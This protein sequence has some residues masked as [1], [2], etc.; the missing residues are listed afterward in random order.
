M[1]GTIPPTFPLRGVLAPVLTPFT[2]DLAPDPD[3]FNR[4]CAWLLAHGCVGLAPFGTTSEANSLG[5]EER[6]ALLEGLVASGVDP[7]R[8]IPGTGCCSLPE[9][10]ALS[11]HAAAL[12]CAGAL[13]LPPFYYKGVSD[14]GLFRAYSEV[15]QR[16]GD[17]RLKIFLY[18]IP[19]V[20][21]V[22]VSPALVERLLKAYP[23]TVVGVK[24]SSGDWAN[25]QALLAYARDG[26][27]VFPGSELFLLRGL[28]GGG[29]GCITATANINPGPIAEV[30][31]R[32]REPGADALQAGIDRIRMILQAHGPMVPAL[33]AVRAHFGQDPAWAT[34][35]PP[36]VEL[37]DAA[38]LLADLR[39]AGFTMPDLAF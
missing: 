28:R 14:E 16:V 9:T 25:T 36:M 4:H 38:S 26:L 7:A 1:T 6:K 35:R 23:G 11:A 5:L 32:W 10:A 27:T 20:A 3:R 12:G 2:R 17:A 34:V 33:K 37:D 24:D 22:G 31:R 18:H 29:G 8:L 39:A 21:Q 15:I 30:H 19:P 13:V